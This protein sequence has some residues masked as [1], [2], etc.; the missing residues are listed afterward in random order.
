MRYEGIVYRPPSEARSLIIQV[1]IGCAH[2]TC[3]FCTMYK[4]K[5][6]RVRS[7]DE[8]FADLD[9]ASRAYG[10]QIRRIFLADGDALVLENEKLLRILGYIQEKFP[11]AERVTSYATAQ[12]VLRKSVEELRALRDAGLHMVYMGAESGDE[13][14]LKKIRKDV[15]CA[16]MTAAAERLKKAGIAL[17]VTFISGLG[18]RARRDEHALASARLV[19]AMKPEY[20]GF[21]T[22]MLEE[23]APIL[24][25]IRSGQLELLR[26]EDVLEEMR[27]FLKHVDSEETVFR[28]NHASNYIVLKGTLNRDIPDMLA[29]LDEVEKRQNYRPES[30]RLL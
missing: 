5:K 4:E 14:I 26:P 3:T 21:L 20:V 27:I 13:E 2:N 18:G 30:A 10:N 6:F 1:T 15:T 25:E 12:D 16:E 11:N 7:L 17:S 9:D 23:P 24:E 22:L 28:S 29:Y 19:S 8:I